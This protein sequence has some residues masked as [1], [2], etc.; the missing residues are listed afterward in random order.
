M[1]KKITEV[2]T[3]PG[4]TAVIVEPVSAEEE[5]QLSGA[6]YMPLAV[7]NTWRY[8]V[9]RSGPVAGTSEMVY[10]VTEHVEE[11]FQAPCFLILMRPDPYRVRSLNPDMTMC[12]AAE[13]RGL[14]SYSGTFTYP[15]GGYYES[16]GMGVYEFDPPFVVLPAA[17]APQAT[18]EWQGTAGG[19]ERRFTSRFAG[20]DTCEVP[21][22]IF[23]CIMI[24]QVDSY[25]GTPKRHEFWFAKDIG[26]VKW[27]QPEIKMELLSYNLTP[28]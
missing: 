12:F 5:P 3:P 4:A 20:F 6:S 9:E 18:W 25:Y 23:E 28:P 15:S 21:A 27:A 2:E 22:G 10:K 24:E 16:H 13:P 19:S 1:H 8:Q 14:I 17:M 11:H 26:L 7:G